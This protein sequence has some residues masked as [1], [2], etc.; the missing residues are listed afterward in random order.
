MVV[1]VVVHG[2][3]LVAATLG[4]VRMWRMHGHARDVMIV[5]ALLVAGYT[6]FHAIVQPAVRYILPAV[7]LAALLAAASLRAE[8]HA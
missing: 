8:S 2:V 7:P 4:A 3:L 1:Y 6:A 5:A